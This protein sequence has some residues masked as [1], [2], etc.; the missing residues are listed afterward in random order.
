M[1]GEKKAEEPS[2][3]PKGQDNSEA[4]ARQKSSTISI[5]TVIK[6][7]FLAVP[8]IL[9]IWYGSALTRP[10]FWYVRV[11]GSGPVNYELSEKTLKEVRGNLKKHIKELAFKIGQR[12]YLAPKKLEQAASYIK[13]ELDKRKAKNSVRLLPYKVGDLPK[14]HRYRCTKPRCMFEAKDYDEVSRTI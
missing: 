12:S 3:D 7:L 6:W 8:V 2:P 9:A 5:R 1:S 4:G 13:I 14:K 10:E 11:P